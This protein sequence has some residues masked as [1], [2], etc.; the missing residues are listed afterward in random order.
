MIKKNIDTAMK[1]QDSDIGHEYKSMITER[2]E[3][4]VRNV[5]STGG[6]LLRLHKVVSGR[7]N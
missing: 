3:D 6:K 7:V 1:G 2:Y 4:T 5:V